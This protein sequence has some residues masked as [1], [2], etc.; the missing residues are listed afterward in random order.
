MYEMHRTVGG[1]FF[2]ENHAAP[3]TTTYYVRFYE[4]PQ[5]TPEMVGFSTVTITL[6]ESM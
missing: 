1:F 3:N 6:V 4:K 2:T 5:I